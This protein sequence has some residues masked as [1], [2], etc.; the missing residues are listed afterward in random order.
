MAGRKENLV[1][2]TALFAIGNLGSKL[3]QIVLV[4]YYT[5][6]MTSAEF[7]T[8]DI[9]QAIVSLLVP[10]FSLTIYEGVFR[11][12]MEKEYDKTSVFSTGVVVSLVG[13]LL[14]IIGGFIGASFMPEAYVWLVVANT[15]A[16]MFR[17]LLSQY[18][19]AV[20][21]VG[22]FT[23]DNILLTGVVLLLNIVFITK[24]Q[25]GVNGYIL[26]YVLANAFSALFLYFSLGK[27]RAVRIKSL[28]KD[29]IRQMLIFSA[30]LIPNG[31][32]W[33]VSNFIDRV[34]ITVNL[35]D[36]ANGL[37]AAAHK[38]PSL[39]TVVVTIFFQAWQ[40]SA[41]EEFKK[42]DIAAFYTE[43]HDQIFASVM[44]ISSAL[45]VLCRPITSVFLGAEFVTA[46]QF[47]P[48]L[49]MAMTFFSYAQFLGSIYTANMKT[50]MALATNFVAVIVSITLNLLLV[51]YIGVLG[52]GIAT[53]CS[54]FV[55][56]VVRVKNTHSIVPIKYRVAPVVSAVLI[57][58]AQVIIV[59]ADINPAIT[60]CVGAC[61]TLALAIIF[62]KTF[63][64]LIRFG[65]KLVGKFAGKGA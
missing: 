8:A 15:I 34:I 23:F 3:L 19:R 47:M 40:I 52:S 30:P 53:A 63:A 5:R 44:V 6:V 64:E 54:Y 59:T 17:S 42:N 26:G 13:S 4:P 50:G 25:W 62:R 55:L 61:G 16:V 39:L 12:A 29:I 11:Y 14:L 45:I 1:K 33:W 10:I 43:I 7:G 56:W 22:L 49:L 32:C 9:L 18:A 21:R 35:G 36:A 51:Q 24:M 48:V 2:N 27:I 38:I 41:N 58:L 28:N 65:L 60:Y 20:G 31:I 57:L 46:W 37:Y